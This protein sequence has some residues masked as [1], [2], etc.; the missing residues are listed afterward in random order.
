MQLDVESL[1]T[2]LAVLDHGGMTR[3]A[4]RLDL[5]QSAVSWKIKRLE[6]R[7]G[8]PLLIRDGHSLRPSRAGRAL[9]DNA[10]S[11]VELHDRSV[12][13]L[14]SS[15]LTGIVHLGSNGEVDMD[16]V[17]AMLGRF[18]L[19][20]P[21]IEVRFSIDHSGGIATLIEAGSLDLGIFQAEDDAL[22]DTDTILWTE[23]LVWVTAWDHPHSEEVVPILDFGKYCYYGH[24]TYPI[25]D[26]HG[27]EH[28]V[29]FSGQSS[30]DVRAAARAGIG[31]GVLGAR[32]LGG[33]VVEW[34]RGAALSPLPEVHR[35][36]RSSASEHSEA[37]SALRDAV[38]SELTAPS[39]EG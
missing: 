2:F 32:W 5:S 16:Q 17:A 37:V 19:R 25:L 34:D 4:E 11:I 10:R 24:F 6:Q 39:P 36:V 23:R 21:G 22:Q 38:C 8:R 7:V 35:I 30:E 14:Q 27:I 28:R 12:A 29:A 26:E 13:A 3:A 33:D 15:D 31:V 1:R 18:R 9:I 20:F